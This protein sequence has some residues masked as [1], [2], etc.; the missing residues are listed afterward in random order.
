MKPS[1]NDALL[2]M[3]GGLW[4]CRRAFQINQDHLRWGVVIFFSGL[5]ELFGLQKYPDIR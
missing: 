4:L 1:F 2:K 3:R 5:K